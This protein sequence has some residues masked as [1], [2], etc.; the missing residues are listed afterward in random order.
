MRRN[1]KGNIRSNNSIRFNYLV[2]ENTKNIHYRISKEDALGLNSNIYNNFLPKNLKK[3]QDFTD[4]ESKFN[5]TK[6]NCFKIY[7]L[8]NS[9]KTEKTLNYRS[10]YYKI[11]DND[12]N[13]DD[14]EY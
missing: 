14:E 12:F 3:T 8:S 4:N 7:N 2:N 10:K 13:Y 6:L 5:V 1:Y 11:T 9:N